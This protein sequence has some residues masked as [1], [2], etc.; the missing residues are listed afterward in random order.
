MSETLEARIVEM[1]IR[2]AHQDDTLQT[3]NRLVIDQ[4]QQIET[5]RH[6]VENLRLRLMEVVQAPGI[7]PSLEPPPPHY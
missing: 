5:L 4:Q 6:Q 7:D 2:L 1:E 3:L